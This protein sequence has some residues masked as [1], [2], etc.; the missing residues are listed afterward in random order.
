VAIPPNSIICNE[1][2]GACR[3]PLQQN[4]HLESG[5]METGYREA[6]KFLKATDSEIETNAK[7]SFSKAYNTKAATKC[8]LT[9]FSKLKIQA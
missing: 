3:N 9:D 2:S 6:R 4:C 8:T 7:P 1:P 5:P